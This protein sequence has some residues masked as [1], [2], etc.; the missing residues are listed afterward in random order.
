FIRALNVAPRRSALRWTA[1]PSNGI[2][3]R[4]NTV[5]ETPA[6]DAPTAVLGQTQSGKTWRMFR[7][8]ERHAGPAIFWDVQ[9][10][11]RELC[12]DALR[13]RNVGQVI[14]ELHH[15]REGP[16]PKIVL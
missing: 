3:S 1:D 2:A 4:A 9:F 6:I 10:R 8:F 5:G 7:E 13:V 14:A 11:A 16:P 15:W 12:P